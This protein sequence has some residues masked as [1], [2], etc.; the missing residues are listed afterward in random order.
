M[1]DND[2]IADVLE[3]AADLLFVNGRCKVDA[4]NEKG[5]LCVEGAIA[6]ALGATA[7]DWVRLDGHPAFNALQ[8]YLVDGGMLPK[9]HYGDPTYNPWAWNDYTDDDVHIID[10]LKSCAKSL[11]PS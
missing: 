2:Q 3:K 7:N 8:S 1:M 6:R 10:T 9:M 5:E 4:T 11:R